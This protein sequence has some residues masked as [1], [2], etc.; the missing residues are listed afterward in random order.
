MAKILAV[1]GT[2][3]G[4]T[5]RIVQRIARHLAEQGHVVTVR[6][7]DALRRDVPLDDYDGFLIAASVISGRH[8]AYIQDFVR[9]NASRLSRAP[10]AFV[11]VCGA[12]H[13][14]AEERGE[15]RRYMDEFL[16]KTGWRPRLTV[17]FAGALHYTRYR[18]F[19]RWVMK[20]ISK[21]RGLPTDTSRDY[22][23][24][25]WAAVAEFARQL[26]GILARPMEVAPT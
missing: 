8:Q 5:E 2:S 15:A 14:P 10:S 25:D 3:Y 17:T 19:L 22:E 16:G 9:R 23:F 20:R 21:K 12:A 18:F 24:T 1:Y 4:Q 26:G 6:K 11:S 13:P 7:G